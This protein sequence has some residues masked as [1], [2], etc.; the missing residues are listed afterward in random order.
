MDIILEVNMI[1]RADDYLYFRGMVANDVVRL[2]KYALAEGIPLKEEVTRWVIT[3][4]CLYD[5]KYVALRE[6]KQHWLHSN[7]RRRT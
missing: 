2:Y 3:L 6:Q 7:I 1:K 4:A 5:L